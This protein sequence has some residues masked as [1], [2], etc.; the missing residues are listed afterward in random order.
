MLDIPEKVTKEVILPF[1]ENIATQAAGGAGAVLA[2]AVA[3]RNYLT[4]LMATGDLE[5]AYESAKSGA[6]ETGE[7]FGGLAERIPTT[8]L[9]KK[10]SEYVAKGFNYLLEPVGGIAKEAIRVPLQSLEAVG[11]P[12]AIARPIEDIAQVGAEFGA[13]GLGLKGGG[14][15]KS[16]LRNILAERKGMPP[17]VPTAAQFR[18]AEMR[19]Q[20]QELST[21]ERAKAEFQKPEVKNE[22]EAFLDDVEAKGRAGEEGMLE[23][24]AKR[25]EARTERKAWEEYER[26]PELPEGFDIES[27]PE[28]RAGE[29]PGSASIEKPLSDL[30]PDARRQQGDV[31][32]ID[33]QA[34][35]RIDAG[36]DAEARTNAAL[37]S[38][39]AVEQPQPTKGV[40]GKLGDKLKNEAGSI[41][42]AE[43]KPFYSK[44]EEFINKDMKLS[45]PIDSA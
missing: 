29:Q 8:E 17:A 34:E 1:S 15:V 20:A 45:L 43:R 23:D 28:V 41:I 32:K 22:Y 14:I 19:P 21:L 5:K 38:A 4:T 13:F 7:F 35:Q 2:P 40:F 9:G 25:E 11:L 16:Q 30:R 18:E 42:T 31:S 6:R 36:A 26:F 10:S 24:L 27:I 12:K 3:G 39:K 33:T 37:S 44:L